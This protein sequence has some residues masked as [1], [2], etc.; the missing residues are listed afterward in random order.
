MSTRL[1][2]R[3][4]CGDRPGLDLDRCWWPLLHNTGLFRPFRRLVWRARL[5]GGGARKDADT[6]RSGCVS[7]STG[8]YQT[9]LRNSISLLTAVILSVWS[10]AASS[11]ARRSI[12]DS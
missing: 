5:A 12:A 10:S 1:T 9:V 2:Y 4:E 3:P 6:D 8:R 11:A 7:I